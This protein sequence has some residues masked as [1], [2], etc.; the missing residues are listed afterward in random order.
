MSDYYNYY[1]TCSCSSDKINCITLSSLYKCRFF[2]ELIDEFPTF[3]LLYNLESKL[4]TI[5]KEC[6]ANTDLNNN[7]NKIMRNILFCCHLCNTLT[8]MNDKYI[9]L[10]SMIEYILKNWNDEFRNREFLTELVEKLIMIIK[11]NKNTKILEQVLSKMYS[12][13]VND[14]IFTINSWIYILLDEISCSIY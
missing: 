11:N 4:N 1:E 5:T 6:I 14:S 12:S 10:I 8:G 13:S 3:R 2:H 7:N 9:V